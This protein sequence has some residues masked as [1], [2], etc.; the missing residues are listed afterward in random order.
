MSF[1]KVPITAIRRLSIYAR[2]LAG[3]EADGKPKVSSRDLGETASIPST[4][5]RK[6]LAYFGQ[7]GKRGSGYS[8][9]KLGLR[10]RK[11][12]GI[13]RAWNVAL[14]GAG[15]LGRAL[16]SYSGFR[17]QGFRIAAV[18]D[19]SPGKVNKLWKGTRIQNIKELSKTVREKSICIGIVAVPASG[20]QEVADEMCKAG[21]KAVLNF[22]PK[23]LKVPA[24]CMQANVDLAIELENL[25]YFLSKLR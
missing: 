23:R 12:L 19:N 22:A 9:K 20:A 11:I 5:V 10:L 21:I 14:V 3:F 6:D 1:K 18:F 8:V 13:D 17:E 16:F 15:N 7:F 2:M 24:G 4:Q 25:S